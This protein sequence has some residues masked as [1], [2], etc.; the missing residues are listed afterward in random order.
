MCL[1]QAYVWINL[2]SYCEATCSVVCYAKHIKI[3]L[4]N[5]MRYITNA[6]LFSRCY[7]LIAALKGALKLYWRYL[8][9]ACVTYT[10]LSVSALP[11]NQVVTLYVTSLPQG[12]AASKANTRLMSTI[13]CI[14]GGESEH[15][16]NTYS[17]DPSFRSLLPTAL[18]LTMRASVCAFLP[19][20]PHST[21][22]EIDIALLLCSFSWSTFG[23]HTPDEWLLPPARFSRQPGRSFD[24]SRLPLR[25]RKNNK[26]YRKTLFVCLYTR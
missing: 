24:L 6:G 26:A 15:T 21:K 13:Y 19:D 11:C 10:W 8:Y 18:E 5:R 1:K 2:I 23:W 22:T 17:T 14:W 16:H 3:S 20:H 7:V 9:R 12:F 25:E 4:G